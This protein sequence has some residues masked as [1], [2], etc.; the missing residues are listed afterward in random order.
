MLDPRVL[1]AFSDE[2]QKIAFMTPG[3]SALLGTGL[4][5]GTI[6]GAKGKDTFQDAREGKV[7]RRSREEQQKAMLQSFKNRGGE[8]E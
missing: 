8:Q 1:A 2:M 4:V 3:Q 7:M 6:L 5:G